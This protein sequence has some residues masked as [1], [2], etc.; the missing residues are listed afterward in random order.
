MVW[1]IFRRLGRFS[2]SQETAQPLKTEP[3][4]ELP[5]RERRESLCSR[6]AG[7]DFKRRDYE[8]ARERGR[9]LAR[10]TLGA[11]LW[12]QLQAQGYLDLPSR[13]VEGL[14]YRLRV[15]RRIEIHAAG[16]LGPSLLH[17]YLCVNPAYPLPE[18]EFFAQLYICLR[19]RE[20]RVRAVAVPQAYDG[21]TGRTF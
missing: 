14:I 11:A 20:D 3:H 12:D 13:Q 16:S 8:L 7:R 1:E 15:G 19:D 9:E 6:S 4:V 17:R 2:E 21:P 18:I 10:R 5:W